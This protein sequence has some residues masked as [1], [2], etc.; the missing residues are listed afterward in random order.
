MLLLGDIKSAHKV[1]I[2]AAYD[3]VDAWVQESTIDTSSF[4]NT[5]TYGQTSPYGSEST[6]GAANNYQ[7]RLDFKKQKCENI[8]I[9]IEDILDTPGQAMEISN[10]LFIVGAKVG[11]FKISESNQFGTN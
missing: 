4:V 7:F 9:S 5:T 6:Y 1:K 10:V 8:K 2:R 3:F 11:E